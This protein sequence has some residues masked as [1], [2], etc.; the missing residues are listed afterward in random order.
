MNVK[1]IQMIK[2][3]HKRRRH[4]QHKSQLSH[5]SDKDQASIIG[6]GGKSIQ[7]TV[8]H[9]KSPGKE[10][11]KNLLPSV[12][13]KSPGKNRRSGK[14]RNS[15]QFPRFKSQLSAVT[16]KQ[17]TRS[18]SEMSNSKPASRQSGADHN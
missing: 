6:L 5:T 18:S 13:N 11:I 15:P 8:R 1:R 12:T 16:T 9:N 4:Q 7:M 2:P 10:F 14:K 3:E 17:H